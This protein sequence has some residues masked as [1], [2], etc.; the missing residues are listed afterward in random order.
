[1][2]AGLLSDPDV[3]NRLNKSFVSTSMIID[4]LQKRAEVG[5]ELAKQL[6]AHW[7]YPVEMIFLTPAC[8]LVF[9][10]NSV[11]DFSA[12]HPDVPRLAK[13]GTLQVQEE[14]PYSDDQVF[15]KQVA[16]HFQQ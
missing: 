8:K 7:E 6:A 5:D 1:M 4:D 10:L 9:K 12:P 15:L 3:I 14:G 2:R 13:S 16:L 11:Q